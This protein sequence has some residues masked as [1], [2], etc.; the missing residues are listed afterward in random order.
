MSDIAMRLAGR[1]TRR[2][3]TPRHALTPSA[4]A[5]WPV[6]RASLD[7]YKR[8]CVSGQSPLGNVA[9]D[10]RDRQALFDLATR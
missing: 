3:S 7:Q 1:R 2:L 9:G 4:A 8:V 5:E 6:P 10:T